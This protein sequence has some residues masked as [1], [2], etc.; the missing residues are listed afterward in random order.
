MNRMKD[1]GQFKRIRG[2]KKYTL[3]AIKAIIFWNKKRGVYRID[4][5]EPT[6]VDLSG[7]FCMSQCQTFGGG[8]RVAPGAN[9]TQGHGSLVMAWGLSKTRMPVSYTHLTQ[10]TIYSV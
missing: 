5:G 1:E 6:K 9:P 3:L 2:Q 7:L 10:P 4:G 8:Y